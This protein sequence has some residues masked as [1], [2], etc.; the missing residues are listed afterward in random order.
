MAA[1]VDDLRTLY[2][3]AA[4]PGNANPQPEPAA[5]LGGYASHTPW[6][7]GTLHDLFGPRSSNDQAA[8]VVDYR[9]VYV[10]N[11]SPTE[12]VF[13]ATAYLVS[14]VEGGC[15]FDIGLDPT[16]VSF[17]GSGD[18]QA[19]SVASPTAAPAGVSFVT[20]S[21]PASGVVLGDLPPGTGRA[22]W[23][24]RRAAAAP[25]GVTLDGVT[26]AIDFQ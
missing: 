8:G 2:T 4:G 17:V 20:P 24:R 12:T 23:W 15:D 1:T 22:L 25:A 11:A 13:G 7:G 6:S 21:G 5:S 18:A 14:P 9:C 3:T 16:P 26:L 10:Y 19:V